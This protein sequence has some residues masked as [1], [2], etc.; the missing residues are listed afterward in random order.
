[1][2]AAVDYHETVWIPMQDGT[3]LAARMWI[4]RTARENPVPA[5]LEYTPYRRRDGARDGDDRTHPYLA[6]AEYACVKLDIR[7]SGDSEGVL[8]DEYTNQE[9]EDAVQAIAWIAA[10]PWCSGSVGMMGISWGGFNSLQVAARRPP[11][12]KA[13]ITLCSTDDRYA[14]DMHYMG[15]AQLTGNVEWG[16]TFFSLMARSPD[17]AVVGSEWRARW[18][19]RLEA[20]SPMIATSLAHQRRDTY[21]RHGSVCEQIDAI[22]CPVLAVGGWADGYTNTVFRLL[23]NLKVPRLGIVGPWGH[24]YPHLGVPGPAIGFIQEMRRWWDQWLKG[25]DTGIMSEPLLRVFIENW[26]APKATPDAREGRWVGEQTWPPAAPAL[27]IYHLNPD[28]LGD[29]AVRGDPLKLHSNEATGAAS[30]EWCAFAL[31]GLGPEMPL[32]Q[33]C[34][35][36]QSLVFDSSP[37]RDEFDLLGQ[38]ELDLVFLAGSERAN[39][40]VRINDVS[41]EGEVARVTYGVLNLTHLNNHEDPQPLVPGERYRVRVP[42]NCAGHRFGRCHRLRLSLSTAYWPTVWP[43]AQRGVIHV[44]PGESALRMPVRCAGDS[45]TLV[46]FPPAEHTLPTMRD[47]VRTGTVRRS[48]HVDLAT[49]VQT[50]EVLRDDGRSIIRDIGVETGYYKLLR[51]RIHPDDPTSAVAEAQYEF[52]NRNGSDWDSRVRTRTILRCSATDYWLQA[53][54]EASEGERRIFA[55]TWTQRIP[56]DFT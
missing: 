38:P 35:D 29:E 32:D 56:R 40:T 10:Q 46:N 53:D 49:G 19:E 22:G 55:R 8:L 25:K 15:G 54:L 2:T 5:I 23:E 28:G 24:K 3:R 13:I 48:L 18:L 9:Q 33:S 39:L 31:G 52:V 36:A 7:G 42:I 6:A 21:W 37:L 4:P 16:S 30:G 41:P 26:A 11:A 45:D 34:D 14:D 43:S 27:R 12:L 44:M 50:F 20:I 47:V 1:M 17:P 51:Y